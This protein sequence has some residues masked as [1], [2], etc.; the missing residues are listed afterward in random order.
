M[1]FKAHVVTDVYQLFNT[2]A[3]AGVKLANKLTGKSNEE[4]ESLTEPMKPVKKKRKKKYKGTEGKDTID[5]STDESETGND[6]TP[7]RP[8]KH[9]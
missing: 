1:H 9:L 3:I 5:T 4:D 6:A 8:R 2:Y 7:A